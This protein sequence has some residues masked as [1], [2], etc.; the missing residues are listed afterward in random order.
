M[1]FKIL[2]IISILCGSLIVSSAAQNE[3]RTVNNEAFRP[4]E[5]LK[6]RIH[7]GIIDAGE[8]TLEVKEEIQKFGGRDCYHMIG[9]GQSVG[10]F[11]WFFKVKDRY[12]SLVDKQ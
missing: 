1:N 4:G 9:S 10:A 12:E 8:A 5:V 7:Y 3:L 11:N 6:F 2:F